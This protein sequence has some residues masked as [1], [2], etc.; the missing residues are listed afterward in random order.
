MIKSKSTIA[1][2]IQRRVSVMQRCMRGGAVS[3][4]HLLDALQ[5]G[6]SAPDHGGKN[7]Y[8]FAIASRDDLPAFTE[9]LMGWFESNGKD[10][11]VT[12]VAFSGVSA[13]IFVFAHIDDGKIPDYEQEWATAA[14]TQNMLNVLYDYGYACKWN[15]LYKQKYQMASTFLHM[16]DDWVPMGYVMVAHGDEELLAPKKRPDVR[17]YV[18]RLNGDGVQ[19]KYFR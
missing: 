16:P 4:A 11:D 12:R 2:I 19:D 13:Y 7:P 14:A 6:M 17:E 8:R 3:D 5:A 15:S 1:P 10:M 9:N 18:Y